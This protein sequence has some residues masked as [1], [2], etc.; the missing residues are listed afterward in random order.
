VLTIDQIVEYL[1]RTIAQDL[2]S[3]DKT[4]LKRTQ[5]AAGVLMAAAE[6]TRDKETAQRFRIVA[7]HAANKL[8]ELEKDTA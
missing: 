2:L 3:G 8:E 1:E 6:S 4:G 7:A 5:T